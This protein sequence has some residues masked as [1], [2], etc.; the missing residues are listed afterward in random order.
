M[1]TIVIQGASEETASFVEIHGFQV[2][3]AMET[4]VTA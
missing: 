2:E 4:S 3:V 1:I